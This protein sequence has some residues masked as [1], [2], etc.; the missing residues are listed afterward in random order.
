MRRAL[1]LG[2][3]LALFSAACTYD[4]GDARRVLNSPPEQCGVSPPTQATIDVGR[5]LEIDPGQGAGLYIQYSTGGHWQLRTSC[6]TALTDGTRTNGG[7]SCQWDVIVTPEDQRTLVNV[8]GS[9]LEADDQVRAF[10]TDARSYQLLAYTDAD[11][12]GFS[13]DTAPGAGVR[14]DALLD[15]GCA[16]PYIFWVGDG[17][18]HPGAPSNPI[19]LLPSAE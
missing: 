10:P 8:V 9:D 17:A 11:L 14:V 16:L 19:D 4:N 7:A 15:N 1:L 13:F 6:D 5:E 12:D 18:L 2:L 3:P